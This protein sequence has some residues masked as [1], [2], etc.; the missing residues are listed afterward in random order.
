MPP[1]IG[2]EVD[3]AMGEAHRDLLRR[4]EEQ[5]TSA[6]PVTNVFTLSMMCGREASTVSSRLGKTIRASAPRL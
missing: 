4:D 2:L 6:D 1:L 3:C 5:P